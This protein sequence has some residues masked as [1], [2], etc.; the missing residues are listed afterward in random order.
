[1]VLV[2]MCFN[3]GISRFMGFKRMIEALRSEDYDRAAIEMINSRWAKQ[4]RNRS[5]EL[6]KMM[7]GG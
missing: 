2:D 4:V 5:T 6:A 7:V 1:M 3:L